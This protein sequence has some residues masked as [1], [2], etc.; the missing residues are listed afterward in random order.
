MQRNFVIINL[1]LA[2]LILLQVYDGVR[3]R[4]LPV[5]FDALKSGTED[6]RM[7]GALWTLDLSSFGKYAIAGKSEVVHTSNLSNIQ[8]RTYL[9]QRSSLGIIWMSTSRKGTPLS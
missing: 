1:R 2:H 4:A 8:N 3:R 6:D 7:K 9:R 5:L